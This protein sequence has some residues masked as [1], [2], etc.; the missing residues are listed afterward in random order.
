MATIE[1]AFKLK[2]KKKSVLL[3][4]F[5]D[6]KCY[7]KMDLQRGN[8]NGTVTKMSQL[9]TQ[10]QTLRLDLLKKILFCESLLLDPRLVTT[11]HLPQ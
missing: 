4:I 10:K 5:K 3:L 1:E 7:F 11:Q 8:D 2:K 6:R 9:K